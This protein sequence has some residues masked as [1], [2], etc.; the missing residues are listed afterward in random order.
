MATYPHEDDLLDALYA[1]HAAALL[2]YVERL[3]AGDRHLAEDLVQE[4]LLR[5][6]SHAAELDAHSA[7]PWLFTVARHL[8]IDSHRRRRATPAGSEPRP[9]GHPAPDELEQA[10]LSW[11]VTAA[12]RTLSADHREVLAQVHFRDRSVADAA[13]TL[14]IP[15]GTVR[16]RTY[17][18]LRALR[19]ALEQR[20]VIG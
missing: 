15:E 2:A 8:V 9:L 1:E 18:A 6:W 14:G 13:R 19:R 7:R 3:L 5:A 10:L 11:E 12:F 16:S 20:G 17:Y 4:T